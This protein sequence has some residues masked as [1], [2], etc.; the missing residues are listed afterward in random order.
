MPSSW[1][2][3]VLDI[4]RAPVREGRNAAAKPTRIRARSRSPGKV[5]G[6][7]LS[8]ARNGSSTSAVFLRNGRRWARR[9]PAKVA[10]T[11][12]E[13]VGGG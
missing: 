9:M 7:A 3:S 10:D 8:A 12:G 13:A 11:N 6:I 2:V 1:R 4:E 5:S